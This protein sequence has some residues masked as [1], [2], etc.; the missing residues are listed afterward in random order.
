MQIQ[1]AHEE[2]TTTEIG[3]K[4]RGDFFCI[5]INNPMHHITNFFTTIYA[6]SLSLF[7]LLLVLSVL[8]IVMKERLNISSIL[9][10][11]RWCLLG[12]TFFSYISYAFYFFNDNAISVFWERMCNRFADL[13]MFIG[14]LLVPLILMNRNAGTHLYILL[15]VSFSMNIG[16]I[17]E[18]VI[19]YMATHRDYLP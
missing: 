3:T 19:I 9:P 6:T 7:V 8:K 2:E 12:I 11:I 13:I 15:F 14:Q 1:K 17:M 10:I 4:S 16:R 5:I 18:L